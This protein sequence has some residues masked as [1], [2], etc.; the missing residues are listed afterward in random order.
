MG[1]PDERRIPSCPPMEINA[2]L[3]ARKFTWEECFDIPEFEA[4]PSTR[5]ALQLYRRYSLDAFMTPRKF[6]HPRVIREFYHTM[7]TRN[8]IYQDKLFLSTLEEFR[9]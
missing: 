4:H 7:T 1:Q 5:E 6:Y 2:D 8:M 3:T 9:A